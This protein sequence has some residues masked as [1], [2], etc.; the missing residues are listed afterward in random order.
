MERDVTG[1][2]TKRGRWDCSKGRRAKRTYPLGVADLLN[3]GVSGIIPKGASARDFLATIRAVAGENG[4]SSSFSDVAHDSVIIPESPKRVSEAAF[5]A[6]ALTRREREVFALIAAG[7]S[8]TQIARKL[9][10]TTGML[11][12]H[13]AHILRK[14]SG[15]G[16]PRESGE[17]GQL[18]PKD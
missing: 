15:D 4:S 12:R 17:K 8:K 14:T 3:A 10:I 13:V 16:N 7:L 9:H 11:N 2:E 18:H 5:G 1:S 6:V